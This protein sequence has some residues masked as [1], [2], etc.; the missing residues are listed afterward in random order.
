MFLSG[1]GVVVYATSGMPPFDPE[2]LTGARTTQVLDDQDKV[3]ASLHAE[4]NRTEITIDKVPKDLVNAFLAIEDQEFYNHHG[5]NFKGIARALIVNVQEGGKSQG[6]S[7][8]TQQLARSA[9]LSSEK[10]WVRKI[11]EII[12]AFNCIQVFL[13]EF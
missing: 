1:L 8:I 12:L 4:E 5:V 13:V 7:T 11:Q 9:F 10:Q 6:A 2:Q 3:V